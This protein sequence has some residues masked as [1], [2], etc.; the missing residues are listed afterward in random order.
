MKIISETELRVTTLAG[1]AIVFQP[2]EA[3]E[4]SE[5]IGLLAIQ[6]GAKEYN[7]KYVE[8]KEAVIAEFEEVVEVV[9][10]DQTVQVDTDVIEALQKMIE[11]ADPHSFK[12]DGTP[13]AQALN[14]LLGRTVR[15]DEREM[16]WELA[17]NA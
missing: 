7:G 14:K 16:A 3:I 15:T 2:G 17:L 9:E 4:V 8:E 5:E 11:E 13:K 12:T 1:A 10:D 6:L